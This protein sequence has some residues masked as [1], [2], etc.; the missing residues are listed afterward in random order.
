MAYH[1]NAGP[2]PVSVF[3]AAAFIFIIA[4]G[5]T[6]LA[7]FGAWLLKTQKVPF[8]LE[9]DGRGVAF[10]DQ[11]EPALVGW[12]HFRR[13]FMT[14]N[15]LV[16]V[17]LQDTLAIPRRCCSEPEWEQLQQIVRNAIGTPL[18]GEESPA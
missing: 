1:Q 7:G 18:G 6:R 13:W 2:S 16:L 12:E 5:A 14:P 17:A 9:I 10:I 11:G 15:L 4:L 3:G 8:E